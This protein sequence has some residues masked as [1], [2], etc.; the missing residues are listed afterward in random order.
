MILVGESTVKLVASVPSKVTSVTSV[1]PVPVMMTTR[2]SGCSSRVLKKCLNS[3]TISMEM[4]LRRS[5]RFSL[6][7]PT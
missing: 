4:A 1:K 6:S 2:A 7:Q 3:L 5:G